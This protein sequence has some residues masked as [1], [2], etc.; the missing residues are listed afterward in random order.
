MKLFS[1]KLTKYKFI[2]L[3]VFTLVEI[4]SFILIFVEYKSPYLKVFDDAKIVAINKTIS[5]THTLNEIIKLS[6]HRY[7][8]D[9]KL[10][11]KHMSFLLNNE[12]NNKSQF[13]QNLMKDGDKKIYYATLEELKDK[14][15]YY[16]N[17]D[18]RRFL[19][20]DKY[21]N[22]YIKNKSKTQNL[23]DELMNKSI[24]HEL[25]AISYYKANGNLSDINNDSVKKLSAK[26]LISILKTNFIKRFSVKGSNLELLS[27]FILINDEIYLYPPEAYNNSLIYLTRNTYK[28]NDNNNTFPLCIYNQ[29]ISNIKNLTIT[30]NISI[31]E[32]LFPIITNLKSDYEKVLN[33]LCLRIPFG[34]KMNMSDYSYAPFLC[35]EINYTKVFEEIHFKR[36][37]AINL[38]FFSMDFIPIYTDKS[39]VYEDIK[40]VFN[41]TKFG[42]YS[43]NVLKKFSF[44]HFLYVDIF[45]EPSLLKKHEISMEDILQEFDIIKRKIFSAIAI[46]RNTKNEYFTLDIEKTICKSDIYYN[47]KKCSKDTVLLVIYPLR[48]DFNAINSYYIEDPNIA[49]NQTLFYSMS[50]IDNNYNYMK[51]KINQIVVIIIIKLFLFYFISSM[52]LIFLYFIFVQIFYEKEYSPI[53]ELLY[54]IKGGSFFDIKDKNEILQ[55]KQG[56]KMEPNNKEMH[57]IKNLFDYLV[58]TMLLKINLEQNR[59]N[60]SKK[61]EKEKNKKNQI[62]SIHNIKANNALTNK[63]NIDTLNEYMDLI[64]NINNAEIKIMFGFII[65]YDHFRKGFYKLSE[66]EFKNL[67]IDM[68]LYQNKLSNK[69][70]N[71][72]SK[73]KD[74]ISRC[75]KISYLNEYSLTNELSETTLPIIK[76]KLMAQ[77]IYYL[78]AL[79][80]YNQER[81]KASGDKKYNKDNAKKRYEEA[82]KYFIECKNVS[83]L[84]GTD[85]IRQIFSLIMISKC[86]IE[87]K[88]YK[89]SMIN[90]NEALLLYSDLQKAFKDKP[91]FNPKI[92][93]FT[94]NYIFQSIMLTMAQT[95]YNFNKYPQSCWILMKMI[96]TSPFIFNMIHFQS[97]FLLYNCLS[98]IEILNN[99]PFRQTDK[100]KKKMSKMFARINVR[101]LNKEK[102]AYKDSRSSGNTNNLVS[103]PS[104]TNTQV[105]NISI[106]YENMNQ[107]NLKKVNKNK[108]M[109]TNKYSISVSSLNHFS[110]NRYKNITLCISEKLI[111]EINGDELKDVIIK[112]FKKCFSNGIEEDKFGFIQFS[113]NGKKTISIKSDSIEIFLQKL[114]MNK[115]A[116]KI[117][118]ALTQNNNEIQFME[119]SNLFLSIIKSHK[120]SNYEDRGDNIIIIFINTSDIRFNGEKECVDTIN[121][122]NNNNYSVIL[123]TYDNEIEPEKIEGIYSFVYGLNDGHFFKAKNYQQ[124]KQV[125]MNFCVKDS[126]EKFNN[127]NYEITDFML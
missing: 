94:E 91:Y 88:N 45:K 92:M 107:S 29:I 8:Q 21:N 84:L 86:Y 31:N 57:E 78:Y 12:I 6:L 11:G 106:S 15:P 122:L 65:S 17:E 52:C 56:M 120:Q 104:A 127:Y 10:A 100:Y 68:N 102:N 111:Q 97:S 34:Q 60:T 41:D 114:E 47:S 93:M 1:E 124:I 80:I 48:I 79:S 98:Q 73:L 90:I 85:T 75:S 105:N 64:N 72:D 109:Y 24:H 23:M 110:R 25:N 46:F 63:N 123:F 115:M 20:L 77:K 58:K 38:I 74:S 18:E 36:K 89:E 96:E 27:Y 3:P 112:F 101:L 35:M 13:Y 113:C 33:F 49:L 76:V 116:F 108:E 50:F 87:L 28:C 83:I 4:S 121:E 44:F 42:N 117:N 39:E 32:H 59:N 26:Y 22:D 2:I 7:L 61:E 66:N 118:D 14:F 126:Q 53:N 62:N 55:K 30:R 125:F 70:E 81:I 19:Y 69:N 119:F 54:I 82:I 43:I 37:E 67:I 5:I 16:Y 95:T 40:K 99:L 71:N 9:L 51:W 103:N